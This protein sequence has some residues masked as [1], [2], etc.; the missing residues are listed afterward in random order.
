M[1]LVKFVSVVA[2]LVSAS[3]LS[4]GPAAAQGTG[5]DPGH[6]ASAPRVEGTPSGSAIVMPSAVT[7]FGTA[8]RVWF[9]RFYANVWAAQRTPTFAAPA[10][11][12]NRKRLSRT[13]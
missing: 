8:L 5:S 3:L 12:A 7:E 9:A 1:R 6:W 4:A 2:L 10:E 11:V 13:L